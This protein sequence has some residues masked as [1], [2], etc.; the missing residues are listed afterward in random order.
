M[1]N[2]GNTIKTQGWIEIEDIF[3]KEI[4]NCT[5]VK[6]IKQNESAEHIKLEVMSRAKTAKIVKRAMLKI[7]RLGSEE[8]APKKVVY[9]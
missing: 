6:N 3:D 8:E 2:I 7:N 5:D 1:N 9:R 4:L